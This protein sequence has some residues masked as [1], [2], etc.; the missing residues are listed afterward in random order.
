MTRDG[1]AADAKRLIDALASTPRFAGSAGEARAR[2]V[3]ETELG[4]SGF[5]VG[6]RKFGFSEWPGRWG[7]P[8]TAGWLFLGIVV[9]AVGAGR[10]WRVGGLAF[11][12]VVVLGNRIIRPI[13]NSA[14][15]KTPW[16]RRMAVN[17]E[18][19][20]GEAR[21]W[22]VAHLDT[23]SQS[24]PMLFRVAGHVALLAV[25]AIETIALLVSAWRGGPAIHWNWFVMAGAIAAVPSLL[26]FVG[27]KSPGALDNATGVAAVL[28][29]ARLVPPERSL[30][31]LI[32]S[33]EELDLAGARAWAGTAGPGAVMLNCDT[34]DEKGDWRCMYAKGP[35]VPTAAAEKAAKKLGLA[36]RMGRVIPGIITDSL[37][38][39]TA[40]LPSVTVSRGT[41]RTLARLHTAGDKPDSLSG[42]GAATAARL[43]AEMVEELS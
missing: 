13:R 9:V 40:G 31:I 36:L 4:N 17:I 14:T 18:A 34:I 7:I 26:C 1:L 29:A 25:L 32:T 43:L 42:A 3:C 27:N 37:A 33:G 6:E 8:L 41:L 2:L 15:R 16:L 39:E 11:L 35:N 12:L 30:G 38:F 28:V 24:I 10:N 5:V 22:L 23:K 21:L 19:T 20:R